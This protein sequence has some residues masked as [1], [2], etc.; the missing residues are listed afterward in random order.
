MV[1]TE[2]AKSSSRTVRRMISIDVLQQ[3]RIAQARAQQ[4]GR[5]GVAPRATAGRPAPP[6]WLA[7]WSAS[8]GAA[9]STAA[10]RS[11]SAGIA[12][13]QRQELHAGRLARQE[14]VEPVERRVGLRLAGQRGQ[15]ARQQLSHQLA[16]PL[17]AQRAHVPGLPAAHRRDDAVGFCEA[18]R[19]QRG[20]GV[21]PAL[22]RRR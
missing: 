18:E 21:G 1:A 6:G 11:S 16:R 17:R 7:R 14:R 4:A 15:H 13:E 20:H 10:M 12:L 2:T 3:P 22:R 19:A 5:I 8:D 9:P